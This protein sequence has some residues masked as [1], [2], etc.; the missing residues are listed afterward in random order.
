VLLGP[1]AGKAVATVDLAEVRAALQG[2]ARSLGA[3]V[4]F[5]LGRLELTV[6]E[7]P[8]W[9]I[10]GPLVWAEIERAHLIF[11]RT[12]VEGVL[13]RRVVLDGRLPEM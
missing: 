8:N 4:D 2:R 10:L 6:V 5:T 12:T 3:E 11:R 7:P 13:R 9:Q 1:T